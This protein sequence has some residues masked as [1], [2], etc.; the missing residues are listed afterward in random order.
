VQYRLDFEQTLRVHKV[1][2]C[3]HAQRENRGRRPLE[4]LVAWRSTPPRE[5]C[6]RGPQV[7]HN[8]TSTDYR[9]KDRDSK[10]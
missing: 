5:T 7:N 9:V 6:K 3:M 8:K 1:E 10:K 2:N 4:L